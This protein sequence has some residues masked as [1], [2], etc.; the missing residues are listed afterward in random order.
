MTNIPYELVV[1]CIED[2]MQG[3]CQFH[4]PQTGGKMSAMHAH[5]IDDKLTQLIAKLMQLFPA[6]FF[7]VCGRIDR[8]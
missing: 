4:Y 7:K 1:G 3:D 2:V 8:L 6:Q 5:C